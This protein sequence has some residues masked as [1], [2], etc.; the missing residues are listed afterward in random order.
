[1]TDKSKIAS[2]SCVVFHALQPCPRDLVAIRRAVVYHARSGH[3]FSAGIECRHCTLVYLLIMTM[4]VQKRFLSLNEY[5]L[6]YAAY[7][8]SVQHREITKGKHHISHVIE[9]F[10]NPCRLELLIEKYRLGYWV[11]DTFESNCR[12]KNTP[13]EYM[14]KCCLMVLS[15]QFV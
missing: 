1:M 14:G 12:I 15:Q 10:F 8:L 5:F 3:A 7:V 2:F 4:F 9:L 13:A 11:Y 6:V